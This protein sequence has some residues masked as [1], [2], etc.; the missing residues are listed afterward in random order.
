MEK[1]GR[2]NR[3]GMRGGLE[4]GVGKEGVTPNTPAPPVDSV[5]VRRA[6]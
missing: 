5:M 3:A 4:D 6:T 2:W 1:P